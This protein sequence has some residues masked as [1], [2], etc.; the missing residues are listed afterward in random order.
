[1]RFEVEQSGGVSPRV[2]PFA[3]TSDLLDVCK[4]FPADRGGVM[5][6]TMGG[7]LEVAGSS[8]SRRPSR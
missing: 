1:L 3:L 6:A 5:R 2:E 8:S 7:Q 4:T